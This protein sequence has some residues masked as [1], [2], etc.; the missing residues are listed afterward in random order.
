MVEL[1]DSLLSWAKVMAKPPQNGGKRSGRNETTFSE[2]LEQRPVSNGLSA[3]EKD[4]MG[5]LRCGNLGIM[6][7]RLRIAIR[8]AWATRVSTL[9]CRDKFGDD[10]GQNSDGQVNGEDLVITPPDL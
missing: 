3:I 7:S 2:L 10:L 8:A 4:Y 1:L 5:V 6:S 9:A